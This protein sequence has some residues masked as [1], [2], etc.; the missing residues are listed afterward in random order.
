MRQCYGSHSHVWFYLLVAQQMRSSILSSFKSVLFRKRNSSPVQCSISLR[1]SI[2]DHVSHESTFEVMR[3]FSLWCIKRVR[4][5]F[6]ED[7]ITVGNTPSGKP[8][9]SIL[10][11]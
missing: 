9:L 6:S 3:G 5:V 11:G 2:L 10:I 1:L 8:K 7:N 4:W